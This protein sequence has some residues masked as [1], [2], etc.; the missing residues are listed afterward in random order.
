[1]DQFDNLIP[2]A[3]AYFTEA[4]TTTPMP[5]YS[6]VTL[7][8]VNEHPHPV[9]ADG[10]G[11][12][13]QVF[14]DDTD[15]DPEDPEVSGRQFYDVRVTD[16]S[17]SELYY[18]R[19]VPIIGTTSGEGEGGGGPPVDA[20]ALA[21]TGDVKLKFDYGSEE[22]WVRMNGRTISKTGGVPG[23]T[24]MASDLTQN[25][26]SHLWTRFS[27]KTGNVICPVIGGLG[28]TALAD[29]TAGKSLTL[30]DM[31][32]RAPFGVDEMGSSISSGLI[33]ATYM[34]STAIIAGGSTTPRDT[35]GGF[36]GDDEI[37]LSNINQVPL[38]AHGPGTL[39]GG[40]HGH[41]W[42]ASSNSDSGSDAEGGIMLAFENNINQNTDHAFTGTPTTTLGQQIGGS[43][44][45][46]LDAS[47]VTANAGATTP[48]A[49]E[50]M[51]P[52]MLF[53]FYMKL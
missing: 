51:P 28:L 17:G 31:R 5:T 6:S 32:G 10:N 20:N 34:D 24:E 35:V 40:N 13:P 23:G 53:T 48:A 18:D 47:G 46:N 21:K 8:E 11:R 7:G 27:S 15:P 29:F 4:G 3:L 33:G 38:H 50:N 37:A 44:S 45:F 16:A 26:Y 42:R 19:S 49:H 41:S 2:G 30:P 36:G 43:G 12:W 52:F 1:L 14:F 39:K 22:G 25:L 9:V